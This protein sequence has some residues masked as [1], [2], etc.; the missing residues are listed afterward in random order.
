MS[1]ASYPTHD[2]ALQDEPS[3]LARAGDWSPGFEERSKYLPLWFLPPTILGGVS[4][5]A[6][7]I[8]ELTDL[9]FVLGIVIL[10]GI[11][12][13]ELRTFARR[14]GIGGLIFSGGAL[15]WW[16]YDYLNHW[17]GYRGT[18]VESFELS[19]SSLTEMPAWVLAKA[20]CLHFMFLACM[21]LGLQFRR[22]MFVSRLCFKSI[23]PANSF[24]LFVIILGVFGLSMIPYL[25]FTAEDPIT[26][27]YLMITAGRSAEGPTWLAGRSGNVSTNWGNYLTQ[28]IDLGFIGASLAGLHAILFTR[29]NLQ[30]IICWGIFALNMAL[31]FGSGTRGNVILVA[32]PIVMLLFLKYNFIANMLD[33]RFSTRAY[34]VVL[35]IL[36]GLLLLVQVMAFFRNEGFEIQNFQEV[37]VSN[38]KGNEMF[39]TTLPGMSTLPQFG[40]FLDEPF[41]G[42]GV[43][44][45]MPKTIYW[46]VIGPIPRALWPGKP[47][48]PIWAKYNAL[49]TGRSEDNYE[50]TTISR[51]AAG[52]PYFRY[53]IPGLIQI[54]IMYGWI[55]RNCEVGVRQAFD[56]PIA[57]LALLGFATFMFRSFRDLNFQTMYPVVYS[58]VAMS[59]LCLV[60]NAIFGGRSQQEA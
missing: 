28:L 33:R 2:T 39:T 25:F 22:Y 9:A 52:D 26:A 37:E 34:V 13:N 53:G 47:V 15:I 18:S 50:G 35:S 23:E 42:G 32:L 31:A 60:L 55:L 1:I 40:R 51:G 44:Y 38:L 29:S 10:A 56:R 43:I 54:G 59:L 58:A 11:F 16:C 45:T 14:F 7:G 20:T 36:G 49:T 19:A 12:L 57:L 5:A 17:L 21:A 27:I 3:P 46:L 6:G 8:W 41:S 48:D 24:V 4:W 30:R